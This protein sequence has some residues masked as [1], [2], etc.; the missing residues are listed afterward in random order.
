MQVKVNQLPLLSEKEF[1]FPSASLF[2]EERKEQENVCESITDND[3][4]ICYNNKNAEQKFEQIFTLTIKLNRAVCVSERVFT[5]ASVAAEVILAH[6]DDRELHDDFIS[7][8][9]VDGLK[10]LAWK[11]EWIKLAT[12]SDANYINQQI[13]SL[14]TR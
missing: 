13:F 4:I 11:N 2:S 5:D 1:L 12:N 7:V 14:S 8:V 10:A 6:R 9:H 3:Q